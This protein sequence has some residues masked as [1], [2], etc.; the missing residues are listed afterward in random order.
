MERGEL[1]R[2]RATTAKHL[3]AAR[4]LL[5]EVPA[6]GA[7]GATLSGFKE[8]LGHNEMELALYELEDLGSTNNAP[9]EFWREMMYAAGNMQLSDR[10]AEFRRKMDRA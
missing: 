4:E 10:V 6:P 1:E 2:N 3:K 9:A 5:P 8:C 7:D